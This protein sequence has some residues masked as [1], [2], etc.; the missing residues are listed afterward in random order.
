MR[1]SA[2]IRRLVLE[3]G[4]LTAEEIDELTSRRNA[5][6]KLGVG[7]CN[8]EAC[9]DTPKGLRLHIGLFGRRNAGKSS[10]LNAMTRQE[11][12]IVSEI[13]GTTTDPVE[14]PMELLPLGPVLFIDTAGID[15]SGR[16]G[17]EAGAEDPAG[18]RP[19]RP[20]HAGGRRR[21]LGRVRGGNL[22]RVARAGHSR[23]RGLQQVG[24][25]EAAS[26]FVGRTARSEN[27]VCGNGRL[28]R[29]AACWNC[30]RR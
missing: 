14:K 17:R 21:P 10:L 25:C 2:D 20:G 24:P 7:Y 12:S 18:V 13:A 29:G 3:R 28:A 27:S 15:D 4:L 8:N 22:P 26:G 1:P 23:R 19:H 16:P 30:A 5:V 11:V 9:N 6:T